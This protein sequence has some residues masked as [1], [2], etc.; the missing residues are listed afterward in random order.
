MSDEEDYELHPFTVEAMRVYRE[1]SD[2][3]RGEQFQEYVAEQLVD[4]I[5]ALPDV[6]KG[7]VIIDLLTLL[8]CM[9]QAMTIMRMEGVV[10]VEKIDLEEIK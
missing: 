7:I 3:N 6:E 2:D 1:G 9:E 10:G 8:N 5:D 4:A